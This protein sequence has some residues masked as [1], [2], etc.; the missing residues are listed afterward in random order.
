MPEKFISVIVELLPAIHDIEQR[1]DRNAGRAFNIFANLWEVNETVTSR[2]LSFLLDANAAHGQ[3]GSFIRAFVEC[4]IPE[5]RSGFDF[6]KARRGLTSERIDVVI[7]DG[8]YWIGI[9]N[10]VFHA[11]EMQRQVGR[12]LDALR[13]ASNQKDYRLV[14]LD[15]RG[16][17]PTKNSY[18]DADKEAH[19]GRC[20]VV[21][22]MQDEEIQQTLPRRRV[23]KFNRPCRSAE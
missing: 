15:P 18:P 20:V 5:W 8:R 23:K 19:Q 9:E 13:E 22:W 4:F 3:G 21:P 12:Y 17:S 1:L 6:T 2:N 11:P 16:A 7:T 14:Y 10:K